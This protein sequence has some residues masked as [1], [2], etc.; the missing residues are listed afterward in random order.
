M[1]RLDK[2]AE[3]VLEY[4]R[5][6]ADVARIAEL[7]R[8]LAKADRAIRFFLDPVLAADWD[9]EAW[10]AGK[11]PPPPD[12]SLCRVQELED[13]LRS[14]IARIRRVGGYATPEEQNDLRNA[15][16]VLRSGT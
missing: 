9:G 5:D 12:P 8:K 14:L 15:E 13:A 2:L 11:G 6:P 16:R 10:L 1:S 7:E 4:A 3:R